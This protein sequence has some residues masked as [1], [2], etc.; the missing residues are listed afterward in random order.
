MYTYN[1][2]AVRAFIESGVD[3]ITVPVELNSKEI[4]N[5]DNSRSEIIIYGYYPL[6]TTAGCVH[7]NSTA[8]D[9]KPQ[10]LYLRDRY[11]KDFPVKNN[12]NACYNT[13]Y[14][15]LPTM[16]FKQEKILAKNGINSFR[17]N[18]TI[19]SQEE[20]KN[21]INIYKHGDMI[22]SSIEST[23]GHYKRGVE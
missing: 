3:G 11:N 22:K 14:N 13:I 18:F 9:K 15:S 5:R 7:K 6:M 20:I 1:D 17:F 19:E 12:C 4:M 16:L 23:N 21:I 8:C 2:F 10:L